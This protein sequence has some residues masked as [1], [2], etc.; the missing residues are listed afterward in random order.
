MAK[1]QEGKVHQT[2]RILA[3]LLAVVLATESVGLAIGSKDTAY[4][5]G[6]VPGFEG[7]ERDRTGICQTI[8]IPYDRII[9]LE[10]GQKAGRRVGTAVATTVLF[11][12]IGLVSLLS[13][14]RRHYLTV[15]YKD[16]SGKD[17]VAVLEIG[18]DIVRTTLAIMETRSGKKIE[19]QDEE[20]RKV[21]KSPSKP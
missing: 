11:G 9:D 1:A 10:Y 15:G 17:E 3:A 8:T 4:C 18:K 12:P 2:I 20:A 19:Y 5:G 7:A 13:K 16:D 14:K 21:Q 6:T